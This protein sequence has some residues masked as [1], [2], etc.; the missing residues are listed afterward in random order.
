MSRAFQP[1]TISFPAP[2][3]NTRGRPARQCPSMLL[4][5]SRR[6]PPSRCPSQVKHTLWQQPHMQTQGQNPRCCYPDSTTR[7]AARDRARS[8]PSLPGHIRLKPATHLWT[9][10][11][12]YP[13]HPIDTWTHGPCGSSS[14]C[15]PRCGQPDPSNPRCC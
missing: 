4:P 11:A 7:H 14:A 6:M 5:P 2:T 3:G 10:R 15:L 13:P 8:R 9:I 12:A 1:F